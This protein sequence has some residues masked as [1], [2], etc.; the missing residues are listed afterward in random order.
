MQFFASFFLPITLGYMLNYV[1]VIEMEYS[2]GEFAKLLGITKRTL[3]HYDQIGLFSPSKISEKNHRIYTDGD[4]S[5]FQKIATLKYIG[6]SLEEIDKMLDT[7]EEIHDSLVYQKTKLESKKR[8]LEAI[9]ESISDIV[10]NLK[11]GDSVD[12]EQESNVIKMINQERD[13]I[14]E[15]QNLVNLKHRMSIYEKFSPSGNKWKEWLFSKIDFVPQSRVLELGCGNGELWS[16]N[17]DTIP[18]DLDITLSD[19]SPEML[20]T[21]K[22]NLSGIDNIKYEAINIEEIPYPDNSFDTIICEHTIYLLPD[23]EKGLAEISRVLKPNGK[24]YVTLI[25]KE[26]FSEL[27]NLIFDYKKY[28]MGGRE[29]IFRLSSENAKSTIEKYLDVEELIERK[30][31]LEVDDSAFLVNYVVSC[32][33]ASLKKLSMNEKKRLEKHLDKII[34]ED[35][36]IKITNK[37]GLFIL[38]K[39]EVK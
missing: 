28:K 6:F 13:W 33:D 25:S 22:S 18:T 32:G 15:A 30:E 26:H 8:N 5:K 38:K 4:I 19:F 7:N 11:S 31:Y 29:K 35:V 21:A 27:E 34:E 3:H 17:F 36:D 24:A 2:A 37:S 14:Y 9:I 23:I 1:W 20:T 10:D 39:K 16:K 12:W